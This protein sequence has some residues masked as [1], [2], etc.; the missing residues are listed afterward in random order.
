M[1]FY[2]ALRCW[3]IRDE[4]TPSAVE[5][6]RTHPNWAQWFAKK[7]GEDLEAYAAR[8][9]K[10]NIRQRVMEYELATFGSSPLQKSE[11]A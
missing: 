6:K 10:E 7:H 3:P 11:A 8:A 2:A 5:K 4:L 9:A 1:Q